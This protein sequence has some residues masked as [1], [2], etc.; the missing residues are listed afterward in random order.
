MPENTQDAFE[1]LCQIIRDAGILRS[2]QELMEW[3][4]RTMLPPAAGEYR[5]EQVTYLSGLAHARGPIHG[6]ANC[7]ICCPK[8]R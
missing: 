3:D 7:W 2:V 4:E 6:L 5:A 8:A 1:Q